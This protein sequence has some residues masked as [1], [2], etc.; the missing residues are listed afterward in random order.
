MPTKVLVAYWA[1]STHVQTTRDYLAAIADVADYDVD[2]V[3]VAP[4]ATMDFDFGAYDVVFHDSSARLCFEGCVSESYRAAMRA[5]RGLKVLAVQDEYDETNRLRQAILDFGFHVVLT[6][7]PQESLGYVYPRQDFPGVEFVT[8]FTGYAPEDSAGPRSP[9]KPPL[10]DRRIVL[11]YRGRD[12]GGRYGQLAFDK[13]EIG[14][15]MLEI[16]DERGVRCDIAMEA[17][18]RIY[19]SAWLDFVGNCR[20]MLGT[21]SGSN[22]FDFDGSI[23]DNFRRLTT[24][25]GRPPG[26]QEFMAAESLVAVRERE[27]NM[28]QVSP[29]VFECAAMR[30][31]MVLFEGGYS[32]VIAPHEHYIPLAKDFSNA[33]QVLDKLQDIEALEAMTERAY[34]HLIASGRFGYKAFW[35]R[36]GAVIADRLERLPRDRVQEE[37][38]AREPTETA[39]AHFAEK[40]TRAPLGPAHVEER[41][42]RAELEFWVGEMRRLDDTYRDSINRSLEYGA[43]LCGARREQQSGDDEASEIRT[44][45]E[46]LTRLGSRAQRVLA[47][48]SAYSA[49]AEGM[50]AAWQAS[51]HAEAALPKLRALVAFHRER[52]AAYEKEY[53]RFDAVYMGIYEA[54]QQAIADAARK[55][56]REAR[57]AEERALKIELTTKAPPIEALK[58][59]PCAAP[60]LH[61]FLRWLRG[62]DSAA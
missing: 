49:Q 29:R 48:Q 58:A 23:M 3:D 61:R 9:I 1:N 27:I 35:R 46:R 22:V 38:P 7:V 43:Y 41:V 42:A 34:N 40:P 8:V 50:R 16:C 39:K 54:L 21:E 37:M 52:A 31:S 51:A 62:L 36:I 60:V 32:G 19:G 28:G 18:S 20:A 26:Y 44:F 2:Y 17:Q 12:I 24:A 45:E 47:A 59:R 25:L 14:R 5:F 10:R 55:I 11:G 4:S 13:Y 15:R 33:G 6:C 53:R 56:E 57:E 30:T